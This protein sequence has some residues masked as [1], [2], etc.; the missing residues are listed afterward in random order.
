MK[1]LLLLSVLLF[2]INSSALSQIQIFPANPTNIDSIRVL[3]L[4]ATNYDGDLIDSTIW[5]SNQNIVVNVCYSLGVFASPL[6][7]YDTI[8]L[9]ILP[10]GNYDLNYVQQYSYS[11]SFCDFNG[12]TYYEDTTFTVSASPFA[13]TGEINKSNRI[14]IFPNPT[15]GILKFKIDP[16][17]EATQIDVFE[18]IYLYFGNYYR[19]E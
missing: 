6:A 19:I 4:A 11:Y 16:A 18:S 17:I 15:R 10:A 8:N 9:G 12:G 5:R 2:A 1:K 14:S 7:H 13:T 3:K